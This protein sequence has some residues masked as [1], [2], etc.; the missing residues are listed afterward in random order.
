MNFK[1]PRGL[2]FGVCH[3]EGA[4]SNVPQVLPILRPSENELPW[5]KNL[6]FLK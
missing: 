3:H 4:L 2:D 6:S 1:G 5:L